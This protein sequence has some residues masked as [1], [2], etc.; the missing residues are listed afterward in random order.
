MPEGDQPLPVT[1]SAPPDFLPEAVE[2][3]TGVLQ[4]LREA[5]I[6]HAIAGAFALHQHTGIW[7]ATKDLDVFLEAKSIPET[8]LR[9]QRLGFTTRIEDPVWLAKA[10]RGEYFVDLI[11]A[12]GNAVLIVD[13]RWLAR[14]KQCDFLGISCPVL[15]PEEMIASKVFVSRRERFDG[16]DIAHLI[17]ACGRSMD[18]KRLQWLLA[19]HWELLLWA[20]TFFAYAYPAHL[21]VVPQNVWTDLLE[22]L[23]QRVKGHQKDGL[24][25]GSLIDPLMFRIDAAEWGEADLY[26]EFRER[27]LASRVKE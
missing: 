24:F 5:Q 7:R 25:R 4:S 16:A 8:L 17:R 10:W 19:E 12:L 23:E 26:R 6:P 15:Q 11:T 18:W 20:L 22:R 27:Y 21:D 2:C 9:L 3:Y 1:S 13:E 14:T